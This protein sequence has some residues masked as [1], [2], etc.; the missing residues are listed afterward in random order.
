MG[1]RGV[2][3]RE[4]AASGTA[5]IEGTEEAGVGIGTKGSKAEGGIVIGSAVVA[6]PGSDVAETTGLKLKSKGLKSG[7]SVE[8]C[9]LKLV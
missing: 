4:V 5:A 7:A 1:Q 3:E 6:K 8:D 2:A 9:S